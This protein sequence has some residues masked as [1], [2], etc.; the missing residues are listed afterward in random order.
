[1]RLLLLAGYRA[2]ADDGT[3]LGL[4]RTA[5][6]KS[7]LEEQIKYYQAAGYELS[8]VLAGAQ[9]DEQLRA[10]RAL[11][12]CELAFDTTAQP[13]L[14]SN[15]RAGLA[16]AQG[17]AFAVP[18]EFTRRTK[19]VCQFLQNELAKEGFATPHTFLQATSETRAPW[20][21]AFPLLVT[22]N[23]H[24][25]I[26]ETADLRGFIDPRL[27]YLRRPL[28]DSVPLASSDESL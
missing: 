8:V 9:A 15:L 13:D 28:P 19:A 17:A 12:G 5:S 11:T 16:T 25:F 22:M 20:Q 21:M 7:L 2:P 10:C 24:K 1:M 26:R 3:P 6:G 27:S 18:V 23:G 4:K 14:F